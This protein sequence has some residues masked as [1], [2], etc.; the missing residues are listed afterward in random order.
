MADDVLVVHSAGFDTAT[1]RNLR[2]KYDAK[3][4]AKLPIAK[5]RFK[6]APR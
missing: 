2:G 3:G 5:R 1:E 6:T 4:N